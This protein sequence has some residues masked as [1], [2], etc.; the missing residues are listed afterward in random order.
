MRY[1]E[2]MNARAS[3]SNPESLIELFRE[4]ATAAM[5]PM[6]SSGQGDAA[7]QLLA[8]AEALL[9]DGLDPN[10]RN[11]HGETLMGLVAAMTLGTNTIGLAL[12]ES[13]LTHGANPMLHDRPLGNTIVH[14]RSSLLTTNT[15]AYLCRQERTTH[16][17]RDANGG[18][19][20]HY[21][22]EVNPELA[23]GFLEDD[24]FADPGKEY[25]GAEMINARRVSDGLTPLDVLWDGSPMAWDEQMRADRWAMTAALLDRGGDPLLP[26]SD[27]TCVA[28]KLESLVMA[29]MSFA[30]GVEAWPKIE[31]ALNQRRLEQRTLVAPLTTRAT[32]RL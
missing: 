21:L 16:P 31:A 11:E 9:D 29:G 20:L 19:A 3:T 27:D 23:Q 4:V 14:S 15:L 22:A 10:S 13:L 5:S 7:K 12:G 1:H 28:E 25:F 18:N 32:R 17:L 8:R 2:T 30:P 24:V 26:T 6:A